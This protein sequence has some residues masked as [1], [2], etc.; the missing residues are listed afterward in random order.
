MRP[1]VVLASLLL[2]TACAGPAAS[3]S[4]LASFAE[5]SATASATDAPQHTPTPT[6]TASGET[7][8]TLIAAGDIAAC[9]QDADSATAALADGLDGTV[10]TLGD[11]VYPAGSDATYVQCYDPAW[12]GFLDRTRPAIGNHDMQDD[13]GA[14]YHRY[15]GDRAGTPGE[16]WY[17]YDLGAW[18]VVV[19]NSNCEIVACAPD[20]PQ[21]DWLLADLAA[22][23]ARCT[24][25]YWHHPRFTSGPHGDYPPVAP[26]WD[27]LDAADADLVL[28]GHDHLYERFAPQSPDGSPDPSGMRQ[29]TIG[30]GGTALYAAVRVAPNS[31]LIIDDAFGVL[32]LTLHADAYDWR[33]LTVDGAV[34]DAGTGACH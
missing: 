4:R 27:A 3:G 30:T 1:C 13:G 19:L 24:L 26:L 23:D 6:P 20:S 22:S 10:A 2:L 11:T 32:E 25:A 5:A 9:D 7:A 17:S 34:A 12:G 8:A 14:A 28:V 31:E 29:L 16:G 18:H 21:H 15:F 33:F